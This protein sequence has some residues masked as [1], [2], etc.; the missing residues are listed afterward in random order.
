MENNNIK[1][2]CKELTMITGQEIT[3]ENVWPENT[4]R[5]YY[6]PAPEKGQPLLLNHYRGPFFVDIHPDDYEDIKNGVVSPQEYIRKAQW[7]VGYDWGGGSM[8]TGG[9]WQ[10]LDIFDEKVK[11]YLHTLQCRGRIRAAGEIPSDE[12]CANCPAKGNCR[13]ARLKVEGLG[14]LLTGGVYAKEY[15]EYDPRINFFE[16]LSRSFKE[17]VPEG[18]CLRGFFCSENV[19]DD[20]IVLTPNGHHDETEPYSFRATASWGVIRAIMREAPQEW[21]SFAGKFKFVLK[22]SPYE[23]GVLELNEDNLCNV[24]SKYDYVAKAE[25]LSAEAA[26][27]KGFWARIR[28]VFGK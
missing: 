22:E 28:K 8:I 21:D 16:S 13:V 4:S 26:A 18:Y 23:E 3:S 12:K 19:E 9:Y 1:A 5:Y 20:Q 24:Y 7:L 14:S 27:N 15:G 17:K 2:F 6:T 10:H 11:D 25:K